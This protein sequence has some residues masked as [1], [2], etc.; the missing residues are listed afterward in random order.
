MIRI[1][2]LVV[3]FAATAVVVL[4]F[5]A[6]QANYEA[7][8]A[9]WGLAS[10]LLGLGTGRPL[11]AP[12]AFLAVPF[13]M[14]FGVANEYLGSDAPSVAIIVFIWAVG[15][16]ALITISALARMTIEARRRLAG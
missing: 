7:A 5:N 6:D 8:M 1:V 11:W 14:P 2:C 9:L 15:S 13:A 4:L 16:A 10:I 12:F 3:Y